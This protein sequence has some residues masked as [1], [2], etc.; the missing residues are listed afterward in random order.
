MTIAELIVQQ[1]REAG[2]VTLFGMPGGGSNLD[3]VDAA[4]RA[5]LPFVLT[6]TET[7]AAIAALA[8]S[9]ITGRIGAC[10]TTLGPGVSSVVNGIACAYLD[11]APV[12]VFTDCHPSSAAAS[13][14][15]RLDHGA[16]LAPVTTWSA[17]MSAE[18]AGDVMQEAIERALAA[19]MGPVHID[20]PPDVVGQSWRTGG[21]AP[22][23]SLSKDELPAGTRVGSYRIANAKHA[24]LLVGLGA[25]RPD[26]AA[27]IRAFCATHHVPAMV[28]YKAKGVVADDD[29][30]FAGVF[31]NGA[32]ER[33]ILDRADAFVGVGLDPVELL[34][35]P[36][37][38]RQPIVSIASS[39]VDDRHVPF[40]AQLVG[41][42]A[43]GLDHIGQQLDES[44]WNLDELAA[45]VA[46][47]RG[48]VRATSGR[49]TPDLVVRAAASAAP[50]VR[51]TVDAGAHMFPA[52][53][54]W[55]VAQPSGMLISNGLS[56]MGFA[57]PAAI[58]AAFIDRD[59]PVIALTGDGGLLSCAGELLTAARERLR[60]V[61][62]VFSDASLS[63]IAIKQQQR[64]LAPAGVSLGEVAWC[65]MAE[66]VG[67]SSFFATTEDEVAR[68]VAEAVAA[69][70]PSLIEVRVDASGYG[71]ILRAV[72][73]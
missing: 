44:G 53:M 59:Q 57:L 71:E 38:H 3:L 58:G 33:V 62:V 17:T 1:L 46:S 25:R 41:D 60:V 65:A 40:A 61:T 50:G 72:R 6:A 37:T 48:R 68:A 16:L 30:H 66:S 5:G 26:D 29:P 27:A 67:V 36:W 56:T 55:P 31:T 52:T 24:L 32:V 54:L 47:Q 7:G 2:A 73:G 34:P 21:P 10:L 9:E 39:R 42:I 19:P 51:V 64:Q 49:L 70:G 69:D 13:E 43:A 35:R 22:V 14:H 4:S 20:V 18:N 23:L 12:L 63:L 45:D 28:T 15:Q 8:Q 11:R